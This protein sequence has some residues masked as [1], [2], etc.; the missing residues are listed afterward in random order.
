MLPFAELTHVAIKVRIAVLLEEVDVVFIHGS[1]LELHNARVI[2]LS[3]NRNF[4]DSRRGNP[5]TA[6]V[7]VG[8]LDGVLFARLLMLAA[9]DE[10]V[11]TLPQLAHVDVPRDFFLTDL[12]LLLLLLLLLLGLR[13]LLL[14]V[15]VHHFDIFFLTSSDQSL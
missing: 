8:L 6:I 14:V 15:L 13:L 4:T 1:V 7:N 3:Q 2:K 10:A 11:C 9:V 12:V 5:I